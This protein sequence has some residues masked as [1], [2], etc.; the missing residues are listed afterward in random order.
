MGDFWEIPIKHNADEDSHDEDYIFSEDKM[1]LHSEPKQDQI[2]QQNPAIQNKSLSRKTSPGI[3]SLFHE[4]ILD[5]STFT[6][7]KT[8]LPIK[9]NLDLSLLTNTSIHTLSEII[10]D[11]DEARLNHL[12]DGENPKSTEEKESRVENQ[13]E[14]SFENKIEPTLEISVT[15][16]TTDNR[17]SPSNSPTRLTPANSESNDSCSSVKMI[18]LHDFENKNNRETDNQ[19]TTSTKE[20]IETQNKTDDQHSTNTTETNKIESTH[21]SEEVSEETSAEEL[22]IIEK[23]VKHRINRKSKEKEYFIKWENYSSKVN[24]WEPVWSIEDAAP[25][26]VVEYEDKSVN[27]SSKK[28]KRVGGRRSSVAQHQLIQKRKTEL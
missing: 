23:I 18:K 25:L 21:S 28:R 13:E 8:E 15:Y 11:P 10:D 22:Y 14:D 9:S 1:I 20:A 2:E 5:K 24:T 12:L 4:S 27:Q 16:S 7:I 26:L 3:Q 6:D 17:V 19:D